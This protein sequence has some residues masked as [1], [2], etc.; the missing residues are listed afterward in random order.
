MKKIFYICLIFIT[1]TSISKS[2][3]Q[4]S[5]SEY[6]ENIS[7]ILRKINES[8]SYNE[9]KNHNIEMMSILN[10]V[11]PKKKAFLHPFDSLK[12]IMSI[13]SEDKNVRIFSWMIEKQEKKNKEYEY[14]GIIILRSK[15]STHN[16][17]INLRDKSNTIIDPEKKELTPEEWYGCIYYEIISN[18][19][20]KD[21]KY[22]LLGWDGHN[23]ISN[24]KVIEPINIFKDTI[25]FGSPILQQDTITKN[26]FI[27]E[28]H[29]RTVLTLKYDKKEKRIIFD[30][31]VP[32]KEEQKN[33]KQHYVPD[34]TYNCFRYKNKRWI[35]QEDTE[36]LN[37]GIKLKN[38][39]K[40]KKE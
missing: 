21:G 10:K 17:L 30:N 27:I 23:A 24:K 9:K 26:R 37:N 4:D 36:A 25:T 33:I 1:N 32:L 5:I 34:G 8:T 20:K 15:D 18:K 14:F 12:N 13:T 22:I 16:H 19:R 7:L 6:E 3:T 31:L 39:N 38:E 35:Y 40:S 29:E 11:L 28:Y 2:I